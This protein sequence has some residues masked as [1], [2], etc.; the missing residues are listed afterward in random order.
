MTNKSKIIFYKKKSH[1]K[2]I[3]S[4]GFTFESNNEHGNK[5]RF[6]IVQIYILNFP[7]RKF[8]GTIFLR[9]T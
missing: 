3:V 8:I 6:V 5:V 7:E 9:K 1:S 4:E 2:F